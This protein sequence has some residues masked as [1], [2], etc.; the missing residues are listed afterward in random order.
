MGTPSFPYFL[1]SQ[2]LMRH[3]KKSPFDRFGRKDIIVLFLEKTPLS[4]HNELIMPT[5]VS[6]VNQ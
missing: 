4:S 2:R 6:S 5:L 3:L 1:S